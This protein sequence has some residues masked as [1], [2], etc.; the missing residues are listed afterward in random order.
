MGATAY[1]MLTGQPPFT[2]PSLQAVLSMQVADP[3]VPVTRHRPA[4]PPGLA[5]IV[6]RCLEKK[7]ADRFQRA[8]ELL[9]ELDTALTST[10]GFHPRRGARRKP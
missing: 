9:A 10:A 6:M 7:P 8:E 1:E 5:A 2:A 4:V 3:V